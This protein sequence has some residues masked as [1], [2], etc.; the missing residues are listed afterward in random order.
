VRCARR[1]MRLCPKVI[2]NTI[3]NKDK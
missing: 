1:Y 3:N 2:K